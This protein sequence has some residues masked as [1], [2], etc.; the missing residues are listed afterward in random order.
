MYSTSDRPESRT[1]ADRARGARVAALLVGVPVAAAISV[2]ALA[3]PLSI[4]ASPAPVHAGSRATSQLEFTEDCVPS[5]QPATLASD[6]P[7]SVGNATKW[8]GCA[9]D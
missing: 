7:F 4:A 9:G 8:P 5:A 2:G 1:R 3:S 6:V